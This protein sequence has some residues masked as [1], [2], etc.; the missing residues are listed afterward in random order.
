[1]R[2]FADAGDRHGGAQR[3]AVQLLSGRRQRVP[4]SRVRIPDSVTTGASAIPAA[5]RAPIRSARTVRRVAMAT[6][7]R[8][9]TRVRE[10]RAYRARTPVDGGMIRHRSDRTR[11]T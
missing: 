9:P 3:R 1:M 6:A 10:A 2:G 11:A 5:V 4:T 7:A 8:A